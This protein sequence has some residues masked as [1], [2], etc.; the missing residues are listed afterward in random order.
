M[1]TWQTQCLYPQ[2]QDCWLCALHAPQ[3]PLQCGMKNLDVNKKWKHITLTEP[4]S[5][6]AGAGLLIVCSTCSMG[7][8]AT[9]HE[10]FSV[11]KEWKCVPCERWY[12]SCSQTSW[13]PCGIWSYGTEQN[14]TAGGSVEKIRAIPKS[15]GMETTREGNTDVSSHWE[16]TTQFMNYDV[17][18]ALTLQCCVKRH[19]KDIRGLYCPPPIPIRIRSDSMDS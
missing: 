16:V 6:P 15:T 8:A 4:G 13:S 10:N 19:R 12:S 18:H 11:N 7:S 14:G 17:T 5:L 3:V 2:V 1:W 9:W